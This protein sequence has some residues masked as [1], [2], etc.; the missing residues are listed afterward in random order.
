S[1]ARIS[2]SPSGSR[3]RS[4]IWP[5]CAPRR[6]SSRS[7]ETR[8]HRSSRWPTTASSATPSRW[9]QRSPLQSARP[10]PGRKRVIVPSRYQP[11]L[12]ADRVIVRGPPDPE[13]IPMDVAIVGGGPGGLATAIELARLVKR[14][15]EAGGSLGDVQIAVLEKAEGLGEHNLSGAIVNPRAMRELFP[16]MADGDFPFRRPVTGE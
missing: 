12:P 16:E 2:T 4:S 1:S 9:C 14:D 13:A 3:V 8:T 10:A 11:P 6:P 15:T 7:T 5:E